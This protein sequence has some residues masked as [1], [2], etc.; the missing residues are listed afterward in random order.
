MK[1]IICIISAVV[2]SAAIATASDK[3]HSNP[4]LKKPKHGPA[5][6]VPEKEKPA[7]G[8]EK[9]K[10]DTDTAMTAARL[11]KL[12]TNNDHRI[13]REE[14]KGSPMGKADPGKAEKIFK[15]DDKLTAEQLRQRLLESQKESGNN[16]KF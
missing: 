11:T 1:S 15:K 9:S 2:I 12:D 14:F 13:S 4:E 10:H 16:A 3:K 7:S 5:T 8:P 6:T